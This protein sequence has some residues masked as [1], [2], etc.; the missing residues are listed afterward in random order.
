MNERRREAKRDAALAEIGRDVLG[1]E[2]LETR[3]SDEADFH[4][5][6][7]W[8]IRA[9]PEGRLRGWTLRRQGRVAPPTVKEKTMRITAIELAGSSRTT[10]GDGKR[11]LA[12][13]FA[14]ISRRAGDEHITV[15]LLTHAGERTHQVQADDEEDQRCAA[16]MLQR[17]LDGYEGTN[18]EVGDYLRVLQYLAD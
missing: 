9:G 14:R 5:L 12:R 3:K 1:I 4:D 17:A 13:A 16:E 7:V 8:T 2:T 18:S 11:G 15:D 6:A 10:L